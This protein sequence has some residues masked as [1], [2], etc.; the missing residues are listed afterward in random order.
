MPGWL[1]NFNG[2]VGLLSACGIGIMRTSFGNPDVVADYT[3]VDIAIKAM[4]ACAWKHGCTKPKQLDIYNCSTSNVRRITMG[5][6]IDMG[7]EITL[8]IPLDRLIWAP[9]GSITTNRVVNYV[10]VILLHILPA[11]I[12]D[13]ALQFSGK[14]PL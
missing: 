10:R 13:Q 4:I 9:N 6:L 8:E 1:D 3:P 14:K 12:L 11:V 7:R 2:P 5:E